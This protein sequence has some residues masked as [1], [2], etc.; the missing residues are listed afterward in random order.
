MGAITTTFTDRN[1]VIDQSSLKY[2]ESRDEFNTL[3]QNSLHKRI[4]DAVTV[5]C[6]TDAV[7]RTTRHKRTLPS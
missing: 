6:R 7:S 4:I 2:T 3:G 5:E 1:Y